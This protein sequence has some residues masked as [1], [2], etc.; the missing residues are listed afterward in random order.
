VVREKD[1]KY[2]DYSSK[3]FINNQENLFEQ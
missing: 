3:G 2:A 1:G